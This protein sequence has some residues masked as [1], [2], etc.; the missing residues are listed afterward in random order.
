MAGREERRPRALVVDDEP[1]V[2][3]WLRLELEY[4]GW[5][6]ASAADGEQGRRLCAEEPPDMVVLDQMMPGMTGLEA[7]AGM[8]E[9][10]YD[11]PILLFTAHLPAAM[12]TMRELRV[13][14]VSK[15]DRDVL[16]RMIRA[17]KP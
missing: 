1:D 14:A 11:G 9:D 2:R 17:C 4:Q 6:V 10:G 8:R 16:F 13:S 7:A 12:D 3:L 5:E 15:I